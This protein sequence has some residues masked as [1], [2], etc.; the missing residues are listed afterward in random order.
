MK[1]VWIRYYG[2]IPMTRV[3]YL[4]TLAV[5]CLVAV[6]FVVAGVVIGFLPPLEAL[7]HPDPVM[8]RR[9]DALGLFYNW[10]WWFVIVCLVAQVID[11]WVTLGV[12]ARKEAEHKE[13]LVD[14]WRGLAEDRPAAGRSG[15]ARIV[16]PIDDFQ[17]E[18]DRP[19]YRE[20]RE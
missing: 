17:E 8:A 16:T 19:G 9:G 18:R 11:T 4:V 10:W 6:V 13:K 2:L 14:E 1:P 12:F 7:W 20:D 3:G 15:D 5:G